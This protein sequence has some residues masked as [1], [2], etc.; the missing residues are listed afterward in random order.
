MNYGWKPLSKKNDI[1]QLIFEIGRIY[2]WRN[3]MPVSECENVKDDGH[4][5]RFGSVWLYATKHF[6]I[7]SC[8]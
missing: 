1:E 4:M 7:Y 2:R 5:G 6:D 8:I 3:A